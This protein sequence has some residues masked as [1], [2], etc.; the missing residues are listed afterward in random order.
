MADGWIKKIIHYTWRPYIL[1]YLRKDRTITINGM[2]LLV[3][4]GVFHPRFFFSSL[5]LLNFISKKTLQHKSLLE[6]GAGAGMLSVFAAKQG[7][8]VTAS[9]IS[10]KAVDNI[11]FNAEQHQVKIQVIHSNLFERIPQTVFDYVLINPPYYK[12][13]PV[14]E[15]DHAWYCGENLEYFNGL[16]SGLARYVDDNSQVYLILSSDCDLEGISHLASVHFFRME[17][18]ESQKKWWEWNFIYRIRR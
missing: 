9:D 6:L 4:Q 1:Y 13:K 17:L 10:L 2:S 12:R 16:F 8:S 18:V 15:S 11:I 3:K 5:I 14:T 7:A